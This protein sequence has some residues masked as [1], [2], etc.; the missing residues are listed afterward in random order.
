VLTTRLAVNSIRCSGRHGALPG[1]KDAPQPFLVDIAAEV[2]RPG[3]G[4]DLA[5][6]VDYSALA[7]LAAAIVAAESFD[8]I[9]SLAARIAQ[10]CL[11]NCLIERITVRV[12]KP[13]APMPVE[14]GDVFAEVTVSRS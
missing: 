6:T 4:D 2:V 13:A 8:L 9:E 12:H 14:V 5:H 11:E 10:A 3:Q 1:E 7:S